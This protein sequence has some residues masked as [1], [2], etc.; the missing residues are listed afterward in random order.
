[1]LPC[2][3]GSRPSPSRSLGR[4]SPAH[5]C[6]VVVWSPKRQQTPSVSDHQHPAHFRTEE[7]PTHFGLTQ[8][9]IRFASLVTVLHKSKHITKKADLR[10]PKGQACKDNSEKIERT[11]ARTRRPRS[12][13]GSGVSKR[14]RAGSSTP[15]I[16]TTL[17]QTRRC[18]TATVVRDE[19]PTNS[20]RIT[21]ANDRFAPTALVRLCLSGLR[22]NAHPPQDVRAQDL[23]R[24][25]GREHVHERLTRCSVKRCF[26]TGV[27][28]ILAR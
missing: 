16:T 27:S 19:I 8:W 4:F 25:R 1:M 10:N 2:T 22:T 13:A 20:L 3:P 23:A 28:P 24:S 26:R 7:S 5:S 6:V 12:A 14:R 15:S 11:L 9:C 18:L 21:I 17:P